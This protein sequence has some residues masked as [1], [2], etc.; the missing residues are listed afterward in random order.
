[1]NIKNSKRV[2]ILL[3]CFCIIGCGVTEQE[4]FESEYILE[5]YLIALEPLP[6][7]RLSRTVP[8]GQPY[9]FERQAVSRASVQIKL[10]DKNGTISQVYPYV[11]IIDGIYLS[12]KSGAVV[13][14]NRTYELTVTFDNNEDF[15]Q[16]T[17]IV[18]DSFSIIKV[19]RFLTEFQSK[20]QV[21]ITVTRSFYPGR[22]NIFL[23]STESLNPKLEEL[24]PFLKDFFDPEED[25]LKDFIIHES[26][27]FN[28]GNYDLNEDGTLTIKIPWIAIN[29]FGPNKISVNAIDDNF[30][31]FIRSR[32]IQIRGSTLSPGEIPAIIEHVDGGTG[33]FASLSRVSVE[34]LV[35]RPNP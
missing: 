14:P 33:I 13:Q 16:A 11:Q 4:T 19:N 25:D 17:T 5:S 32:D 20:E 34:I 22:Q 7:V 26:P 18:P 28:E 29:F 2:I 24:T 1:M 21:E 10:L 3:F 15:L 35:T 31:D 12:T 6:E 30:F 27:P 23:L 8:F 9:Y